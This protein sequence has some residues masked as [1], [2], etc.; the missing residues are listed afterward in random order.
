MKTKKKKKILVVDDDKGFLEEL[1]SLLELS[2]YDPVS[3]NDEA[4]VL[5][6]LRES[7]ADL[8]L[9][10]LKMPKKS[11]FQ[12]AD[13]IRHFPGYE[14]VPIIA[15]SAY[16]K[17]AYKG[18]LDICGITRCLTKPFPPLNVIVEI[19]KAFLEDQKA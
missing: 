16:Y 14:D 6:K 1:T 19:E 2:G 3:V 17:D 10:D 11:G 8:V 18:F 4:L 13:E 9:I 15:M 7:M 5:Q 12:V